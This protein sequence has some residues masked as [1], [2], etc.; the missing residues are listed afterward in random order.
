MDETRWPV[1]VRMEGK[2]SYR[3]WLWVVVSPRVKYHFLSPSRGSGVPKKFFEYDPDKDQCQWTGSLMVDR[4]SS[5][6]FLAT[7]LKLA[8][9]WA[10][11]RR[12]FVEAQAG[13]EAQQGA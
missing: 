4:F 5:Y 1:F 12:D 10:H 11:V 9:C 3:W 8:F 13:A 6:K 7:L 2:G